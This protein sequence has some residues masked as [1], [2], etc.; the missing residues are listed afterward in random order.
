MKINIQNADKITIEGSNDIY[1][2]MVMILKRERQSDRNQEHFWTLCLGPS[3]MLLN[4]ELV[5]LGTSNRLLL[6]PAEV[7]SI[8][9]QKQASCLILVHNHPSGNL[10]PSQPDK[11]MTDRLIQI[12]NF[13]NLPVLD[14][15]IVTEKEYFSFLDDG[16]FQWLR[17]HP[18]YVLDFDE[19][20]KQKKEIRT[21]SLKAGRKAGRLRGLKDGR[22]EGEARGMEKGKAEGE[23]LGKATAVLLFLEARGVK[24]TVAERRRIQTCTDGETLE[25][26]VRRAADASSIAQVFDEG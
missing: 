23:A 26:C 18:K 24:M 5:S 25:K 9:L 4:L 1:R 19:I 22:R 7:L 17:E 12:G 20:E 16:L 14:H 6:R 15:M 11:D 21:Q 3:H 8:P 2:I 13:M 10:V